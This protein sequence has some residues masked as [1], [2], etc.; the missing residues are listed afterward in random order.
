MC[1]GVPSPGVLVDRK[2]LYSK[3]P[4]EPCSC[5]NCMY[6]ELAGPQRSPVLGGGYAK[7]GHLGPPIGIQKHVGAFQVPVDDARV[8]VRHRLRHIYCQL[9]HLAHILFFRLC[10]HM[11]D[12]AYR[13]RHIRTGE[14]TSR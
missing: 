11:S 7:V 12:M 10:L 2:V 13:R 4:A 3:P 9:H 6:C 14:R 5:Q 8:A 1:E